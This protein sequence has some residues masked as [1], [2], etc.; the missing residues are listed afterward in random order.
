ML[1]KYVQNHVM[2]LAYIT[3]HSVKRAPICHIFLFFGFLFLRGKEIMHILVQA[4]LH[5]LEQKTQCA[6]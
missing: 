2:N 4:H 6:Y 1:G 5:L 3:N